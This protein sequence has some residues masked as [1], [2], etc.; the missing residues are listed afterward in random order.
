[1][2]T[3]NTKTSYRFLLLLANVHKSTCMFSV[4][5][6]LQ[7][8]FEHHFKPDFRYVIRLRSAGFTG[9]KVAGRL[10]FP[11]WGFSFSLKG[12]ET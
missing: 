11:D 12:E 7:V 1:M 5:I 8:W 9:G 6:F 2:T 4:F 10:L 3:W